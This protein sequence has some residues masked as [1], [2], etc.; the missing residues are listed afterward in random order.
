MEK[1]IIIPDSFKGTMSSLEVSEIIKNR[2]LTYFQAED[3]I[4]IPIADGGEGT[5][6]CF[7]HFT[8]ASRIFAK[9]AGPLMEPVT[10]SYAMFGS[11]AVIE[12][13]SVAGYALP[14]SSKTPLDTTTYGV[15]ELI[16]D[17]VSRG[18]RKIILGLGGSCTNDGGAGLAA[19]LGT[20]FLDKNGR[21]F[22]P[23]GKNLGEA[24]VIDTAETRRLLSGVQI[25]GMCDVTNPLYGENGAAAV[26][27]P[28]KGA[29]PED[30]K[31]LDRQLVLFARAIERCLHMDVSLLKGSGAAGG[32]GAG[33]AAFLQ[34]ELL[35]GIDLILDLADFEKLLERSRFVVTG[36]GKLDRQ[37]LSGKVIAGIG[38]RAKAKQIPVA[39]ITGQKEPGLTG[40]EE[41]GIKAVFETGKLD[42]EK[43]LSELLASCRRNLAGAA[44][45]LGRYLCQ[46]P[47][48]NASEKSRL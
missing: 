33:I 24:E 9:A 17:A 35:S 45:R 44:D 16:R 7:M 4:T 23:T 1:I 46:Y 22:L 8:G 11:T 48:D 34:G 42:P 14:P 43:P 40:L 28:Q 30:V 2:L 38:S 29:S 12:T 5:V 31:L 27:A 18:C 3:L 26:F 39:A 41:L 36:E 10:A 15:G 25:I 6:D 32:M 47:S 13:A 20:T 21:A 37:S 19:A